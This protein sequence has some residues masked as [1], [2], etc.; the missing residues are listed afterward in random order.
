M[1]VSKAHKHPTIHG[2]TPF[3]LWASEWCLLRS[4]VAGCAHTEE[5]MHCVFTYYVIT[6][7]GIHCGTGDTKYK[8]TL[9]PRNTKILIFFHRGMKN[10]REE[11]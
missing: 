9:G 1:G 10:E 8:Q 11:L 2:A 5:W 7:I 3:G 6:H 4:L